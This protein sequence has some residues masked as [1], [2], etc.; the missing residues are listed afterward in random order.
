MGDTL[1][2]DEIDEAVTLG[3]LFAVAEDEFYVVAAV[4]GAT[5]TLEAGA[6]L[7]DESAQTVTV[8]AFT[9]VSYNFFDNTIERS[10]GSTWSRLIASH[11]A[12]RP[13]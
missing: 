4:D 6:G 3:Q 7:L 2:G 9:T 13:A 5:L 8:E 11:A 1:A 10:A 12:S